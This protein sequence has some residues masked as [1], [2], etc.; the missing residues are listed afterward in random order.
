MCTGPH[1]Q[2]ELGKVPATAHMGPSPPG[3]SSPAMQANQHSNQPTHHYITPPT[4]S[5]Q[6]SSHSP[7][8]PLLLLSIM[9][10]AHNFLLCSL[11]MVST[12]PS[13][14]PPSPYLQQVLHQHHIGKFLY[15]YLLV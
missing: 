13:Q 5:P 15:F 3:I 9:V 4:G 7:T 2:Q 1:P 11:L 14:I 10:G 6:P 8:H 12:C